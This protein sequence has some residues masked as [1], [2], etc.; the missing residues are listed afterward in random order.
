M[1]LAR[2]T[3]ATVC[4]V[5]PGEKVPVDGVVVDGR[6]AVDESM[7]TGEPMPVEK[8]ARDRV[9]GGTMNTTGSLLVRADRVGAD[10]VLAQIVQHGRRSA[11]HASADPAC[12]GSVAAYFVPA[13]VLVAVLAF[14]A[15]S[16][17]D[18]RRAWPLR[19]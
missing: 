19:W 7:I 13:V 15:W 10:T 6:S 16:R 9:T 17:G 5:R 2:S 14:V 4:R 8:A 18:R 12:R 3:S 1:P 11:A